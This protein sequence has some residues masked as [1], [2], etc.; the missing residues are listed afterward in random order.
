MNRT[1]CLFCQREFNDYP[2]PY[3]T[4]FCSAR[5]EAN[6]YILNDNHL[7]WLFA[8]EFRMEYKLE[9]KANDTN[10]QT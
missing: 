6:H 9:R 7:R 3:S 8:N 5:C 1:E 2:H 4:G 10:N